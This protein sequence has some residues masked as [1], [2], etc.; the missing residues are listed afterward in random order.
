MKHFPLAIGKYTY[1]NAEYLKNYDG[2]TIDFFI[3]KTFD[4]GFGIKVGA[5][6]SIKVRLYGIDTP[7][8]KSKDEKEKQK[9]YEAKEYVESVLTIAESIQ[10]NTFKDKTGKYGRYLATVLYT[11]DDESY[12]LNEEL[13]KRGLAVEKKY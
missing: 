3:S 5:S 10:V 7:E 12:C 4:F 11:I 1:D 2:D 6:Y 8:I 13:V 9:A